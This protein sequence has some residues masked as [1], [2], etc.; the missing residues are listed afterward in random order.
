M[1]NEILKTKNKIP[2]INIKHNIEVKSKWVIQIF[3]LDDIQK[4]MRR[5]N[6]GI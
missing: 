3:F 1:Q 4:I 2:D 5:L 6:N